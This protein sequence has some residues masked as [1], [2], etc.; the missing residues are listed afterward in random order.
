MAIYHFPPPPSAQRW[1]QLLYEYLT[2]RVRFSGWLS[3]DFPLD[4]GSPQCSLLFLLLFV[5][6]A[7]R[8][9]A[10][11]RQQAQLGLFS[12]I[13]RLDGSSVN[14]RTSTDETTLHVRTR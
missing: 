13:K 11:L 12:P 6:A 14:L 5:V 3:Q 9:A 2:T 8:L 4:T 10:S 1:V 7:Q